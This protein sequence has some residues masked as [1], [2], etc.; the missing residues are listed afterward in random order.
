MKVDHINIQDLRKVFGSS[1]TEQKLREAMGIPNAFPR[2][3][4]CLA[5]LIDQTLKAADQKEIEDVW[6][7]T[8][9]D[10][11]ALANSLFA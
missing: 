7:G 9:D 1:C 8:P 3:M 11:K 4:T 2:R 10:V 5:D 6:K